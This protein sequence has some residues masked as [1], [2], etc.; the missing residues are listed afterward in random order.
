VH[1]AGITFV[2]DISNRV[3]LIEAVDASPY[4]DITIEHTTVLGGDAH[5][6]QI[7][8]NVQAVT[9]DACRIDGG[10]AHHSVTIE[11]DDTTG[12]PATCTWAPSDIRLTHSD[13]SKLRF[14]GDPSCETDGA[15]EDTLQVEGAGD[16]VEVTNNR[17]GDNPDPDAEDCVDIK[18][19]GVPGARFV[20]AR[21]IV[22]ATSCTKE[23]M[24]F[25]GNR[26]DPAAAV[27]EAN[28]WKGTLTDGPTFRTSTQFTFRNNVL[29]GARLR[30][31]N[32]MQA[33]VVHNT[34]VGG[35]LDIGGG[36]SACSSGLTLA[37]N[38]FAGTTF[39]IDDPSRCD[40]LR[41]S[42][43]PFDGTAP[44]VCEGGGRDGESCHRH[45][46]LCAPGK[47]STDDI[48]A[49]D[50][51]CEGGTCVDDRWPRLDVLS[52]NL[53]FEE[54]GKALRRCGAACANSDAACSG[55]EDCAGC[56]GGCL[57]ATDTT[58]NHPGLVTTDPR[59]GSRGWDIAAASPALDAA[60]AVFATSEDVE[61]DSRPQGQGPDI[62]GDELSLG[63]AADVDCD[64][65]EDCTLDACHGGVCSHDPVADGV[66]C[67]VSTGI[68]C[69]GT[70]S[71]PAC[72]SDTTCADS[73]ACTADLC[74]NPGTCAAACA[75]Q[76]PPCGAGDG[77]CAPGCN[78]S[79]PD[80]VTSACGDG[81][82]E[83]GG[84]N[85]FSCPADCRCTGK[86]CSKSCCGDGVC[87]RENS[88]SCPADCGG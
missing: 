32:G 56:A 72:S 69:G 70:C 67:G 80:C 24:V 57:S 33:V 62:G 41:C 14:D 75:S 36:G 19:E 37:S 18:G 81:V 83:G 84:E 47:C 48:C 53:V 6:V 76:W 13:L 77:C 23:G 15:C 61:G 11:C 12:E 87:E 60:D 59:L 26:A 2:D 78:G 65:R 35:K 38:V 58:A 40:V 51:E 31:I 52:S 88:R 22:D 10:R 66:A 44:G 25:H 54:V 71:L 28:Y 34:F 46:T 21:N 73:E 86:S 8:G 3:V 27:V 17:F 68:C 43:G 45:G 49:N 85:C 55:D 64:D 42:G 79:D 29:D 5:A 4:R 82:C 16:D 7:R 63:C 9:F 1:V 74:L 30:I 39:E 50:Q 20:F